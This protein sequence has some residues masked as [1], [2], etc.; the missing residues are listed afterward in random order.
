M[1]VNYIWFISQPYHRENSWCTQLPPEMRIPWIPW[2]PW[3]RKATI[4]SNFPILQ[5]WNVNIIWC[6]WFCETI[7]VGTGMI[8]EDYFVALRRQQH[9]LT[10]VTDVHVFL[11]GLVVRE[12]ISYER[13]AWII[14]CD[15]RGF[16]AWPRG[17]CDTGAILNG[18]V[19]KTAYLKPDM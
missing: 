6:W 1:L 13:Y 14:V 12:W 17:V 19:W 4:F 11:F 18:L 16:I 10:Y 3:P 8:L 5:L 9:N 2:I 7:C 15:L